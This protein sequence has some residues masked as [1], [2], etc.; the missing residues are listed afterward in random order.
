MPFNLSAVILAENTAPLLLG[1][2]LTVGYQEGI[3]HWYLKSTAISC[4]AMVIIEL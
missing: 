1:E 3:Q 4:N 2:I